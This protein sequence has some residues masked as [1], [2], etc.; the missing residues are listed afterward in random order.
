[1][2]QYFGEK[3]VEYLAFVAKLP[4]SDPYKE[5]VILFVV[6]RMKWL[7]FKQKQR[8]RDRY[9][10]VNNLYPLYNIEVATLKKKMGAQRGG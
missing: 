2:P 9:F 3:T 7:H 4:T 5:V 1:M 8:V 6:C 10:S